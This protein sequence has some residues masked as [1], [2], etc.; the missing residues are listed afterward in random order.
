MYSDARSTPPV[1]QLEIEGTSLDDCRKK[2]YALYGTDYTIS[3]YKTVPKTSFFGLR[4][5]L[6]V[7]A[8]YFLRGQGVGVGVGA[9]LSRMNPYPQMGG[10][11]AQM[12]LAKGMGV[13]G[14]LSTADAAPL[15]SIPAGGGQNDFL[16]SRDELLE[17]RASSSIASILEVSKMSKQIA[18]MSR[19]IDSLSRESASKE[20]HPSIVKIDEIL[21]QNEFNQYY[22][23]KMNERIR[24]EFSLDSLDDFDTVQRT[25]VDWIGGDIHIAPHF[26]PKSPQVIVV[27]GPTGVGKTSTIAKMAAEIKISAKKAH[28]PAP[29]IHMIVAD[30]MRVAAKEQLE[31]YGEA[32]EVSVEKADTQEDLKKLF[33]GYN[34]SKVDFIFIDTGGYSPNDFENIAKMQEMLEIPGMKPETYLAIAASTKARDL[35]KIIRNYEPFDFRS[36]IITKCDET[37]TYGNVLSVLY[38][39]NK[40]IAML[41]TGQA[42]LHHLERA[43]PLYFLRRLDGFV[44]DEE[45]IK[46]NFGSDDESKSDID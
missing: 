24:A 10:P 11:A 5:K 39:K 38:A 32:L 8:T 6:V 46:Q 18:E 30:T 2:L 34:T 9:P 22:I 16:R 41:T 29:V 13:P 26:E 25:V 3:N 21:K 43:A 14:G 40:K 31:H 37:S 28:R 33:N 42:V 20:E 27:V 23:D 44:K 35:E 4:Q 45:H 17:K 19:K 15:N 7:Q 1:P 12:P 36:I